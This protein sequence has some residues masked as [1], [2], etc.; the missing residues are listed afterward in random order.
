MT[1]EGIVNLVV[2]L[3]SLIA[4]GA[5]VAAYD[6]RAAL[7]VVGGVVLIFNTVINLHGGRK[8]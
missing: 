1:R 5:G 4:I 3:A 7:A 2:S 6:W 8:E